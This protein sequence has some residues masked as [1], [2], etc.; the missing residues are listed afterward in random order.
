MKTRRNLFIT[1]I[2]LIVAVCI[3]A[4]STSY[5]IFNI[6]VTK[7]K[8]FKVAIGNLELTLDDQNNTFTDG[9]IVASNM[10]PARDNVGITSTG[11]NFTLKNTGSIDA[12]YSIYLDDVVLSTLP[13]GTDGRLDN[14][15]V[16]VNLTN[17]TTNTSKTYTLSQI[18]NRLLE[19]GTLDSGDSNSYVLRMWLDYTAGNEAQNKYYATKIR[20]DSVQK[21]YNQPGLYDANDNLIVKWDTL[22]NQYGLDVTHDYS[23]NDF[24]E[25]TYAPLN[26][27]QLGYILSHNLEL[28]TATKIVVDNVAKIGKSAF[29]NCPTLIDVVL[30]ETITSI[31]EGAFAGDINL[32]NINLPSGITRIEHGTF[33][34]CNIES[35]IIPYGVTSVGEESFLDNHNL[36]S[37]TIPSSVTNI[38]R[39]AFG[40]CENLSNVVFGD[41][42]N[43]SDDNSNVDSSILANPSQAASLLVSTSGNTSYYK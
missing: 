16:R 12:S 19:S 17:T 36:K 23:I 22:T 33:Y 40:N 18:H 7:N 42:Y 28:S 20:V 31:G 3:L 5:A 39:S 21:V 4:I 10:V 29:A 9:K 41:P 14:S 37:V 27:K 26:D 24:D 35:I 2:L 15:L 11:Y 25:E 43:W 13:T 30:P 34:Y 1:I 32:T 8:I 38:G 6:N